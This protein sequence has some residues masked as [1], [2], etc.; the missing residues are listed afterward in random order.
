MREYPIPPKYSAEI[1]T[2]FWL[3]RLMMVE[4]ED[5]DAVLLRAQQEMTLKFILFSLGPQN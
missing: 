2:I 1:K 3:Y 4:K 5:T